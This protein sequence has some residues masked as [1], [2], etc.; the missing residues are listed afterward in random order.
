MLKVSS[1]AATEFFTLALGRNF[2]GFSE[3]GISL[4]AFIF[5]QEKLQFLPTRPPAS[6]LRIN[7]SIFVLHK[8]MSSLFVEGLGRYFPY[9]LGLHESGSL[10]FRT[11]AL[12]LESLL[13][14]EAKMITR[15]KRSQ[16]IS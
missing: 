15:S 14:C 16:R 5:Y 1:D 8:F 12:L 9:V 6:L 13:L 3:V 11:G 7:L 10:L 4:H 2:S